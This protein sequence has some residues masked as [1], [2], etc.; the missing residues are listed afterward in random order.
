VRLSFHNNGLYNFDFEFNMEFVENYEN[1]E[2]GL[3]YDYGGIMVQ[4]VL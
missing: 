3:E 2:L 1:W 4:I